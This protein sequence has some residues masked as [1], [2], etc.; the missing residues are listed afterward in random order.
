MTGA[1]MLRNEGEARGQLTDPFGPLSPA[2]QTRVRSAPLTELEAGADLLL[3]ATSL[4]EL[5][6]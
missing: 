1:E 2:D 3:T 5:R 4:D 6:F